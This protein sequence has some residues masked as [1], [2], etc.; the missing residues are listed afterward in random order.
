MALQGLSILGSLALA[1]G[2]AVDLRVYSH[3]GQAEASVMMAE[4]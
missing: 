1:Y 4:H 3:L 2:V